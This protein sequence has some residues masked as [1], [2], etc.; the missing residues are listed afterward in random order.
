MMIFGFG[1]VKCGTLPWR[2]ADMEMIAL[3]LDCGKR[4]A[5]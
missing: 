1:T 3:I 2:G 4:R 5:D